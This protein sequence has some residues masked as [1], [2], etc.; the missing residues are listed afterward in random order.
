MER[1]PPGFVSLWGVVDNPQAPPRKGRPAWRWAVAIALALVLLYKSL[2]GVEWLRVWQ[3]ILA[4]RWQYLAAGSLTSVVSYVL[5]ALRWRILLNAG[6]AQPLR[7]AA[8]F[9]ANMAGYLGNAVLPARAGEV[10]RSLIVSGESSL[11]RT[12]VLTTALSERLVDAIVLV[13]C[14]SA[15]LLRVPAKPVWLEDVAR[16]MALAA[17]AGAVVLT[18]LPYAEP[19]AYRILHWLPAP[20]AV[21]PKLQGLLGQVLLGVRAFHHPGR[22]LHYVALTAVIWAVDAAGIRIAGLGL[23][24]DMGFSA[25]VLLLAAMGLGSALPS[26]PGYVGI[27]QFVTVTTLGPFGIPRDVALAYSLVTQ[28]LAYVVLAALGTPG[29]YRFLTKGNKNI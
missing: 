25:A 7:A 4:A 20:A 15:I 16:S 10:I 22:L 29:L 26:T 19:L 21:K 5:R 23:H 11:S 27:Y 17:D 9:R 28:A 1:V 2:Q 8:V 6:A 24:V 3:T 18:I 12:Y 13:L 14:G